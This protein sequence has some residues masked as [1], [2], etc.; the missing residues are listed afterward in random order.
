MK[1][2]LYY[3]LLTVLL[4]ACGSNRIAIENSQNVIFEYD[5]NRP[6]NYG[7]TLSVAFYNVNTAGERIDISKNLQ[8]KVQGDGLDYDWKEQMLYIN[9]RPEQKDI[10]E[11][12][13]LI[14]IKEK[15]DSITYSQKVKLNFSGQLTIDLAGKSGKKGFDKLPR[16]RP[17]LLTEGKTGKDGDNGEHG[18]D[19][20]AARLHIWKEDDMCYVRTEII[21]EKTAYY[22]QTINKDNIVIDASGGDGGDGGN[23]GDGSRGSKGKIVEDKK[24]SPGD[25]GDG[26]NG[27]D[28]GNGGN[29]AAVEVIVHPNAQE[30][31]SRLVILNKGGEVGEAGDFGEP[32][33]GGKPAAGQKDGKDGKQGHK[34]AEGKPGK[35]GPTPVI[36]TGSFDF[37]KW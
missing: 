21:G 5:K 31:L 28:A 8:M 30:I 18:E 33:K 34:G 29:G 17:V 32:G 6:I 7:D 15:G 4:S 16:L 11:I 27:G 36:K 13:F 37:N 1:K 25:G 19:A 3:G 26:G 23:G 14:V 2:I 24:Y 10:D 22:Y 20:Q 12:P 9:K 35:D